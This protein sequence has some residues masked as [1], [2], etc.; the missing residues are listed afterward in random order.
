MA[1]MTERKRSRLSP[2]QEA[3]VWKR[4]MAGRS[5]HLLRSQPGSCVLLGTEGPHFTDILQKRFKRTNNPKDKIGR[6]Q[7]SSRAEFRLLAQASEQLDDL[8]DF[9]WRPSDSSA[10]GI[11]KFLIRK[12]SEMSFR[13]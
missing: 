11:D 5:L 2:A 12:A 8:A 3:D 4:W 1:F 7:D 9:A 13:R 6:N 10:P